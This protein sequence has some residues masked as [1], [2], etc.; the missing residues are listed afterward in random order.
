MK[1]TI[2]YLP[3]EE[4][5]AIADVAVLMQMHPGIKIR[6]SE[7]HPPYKHTYLSTKKPKSKCEDE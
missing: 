1:I 6:K 5:Q 3:E 4:P 2:A 7:L